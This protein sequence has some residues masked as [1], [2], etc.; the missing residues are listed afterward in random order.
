ML[1]QQGIHAAA[2]AIPI[3][4]IN[5]GM[6]Q[7]FWPWKWCASRVCAG[8]S[9][10][11]CTSSAPKPGLAGRFFGAG[12]PSG[13]PVNCSRH[14]IP[15]ARDT[16]TAR[17]RPAGKT[18]MRL[19]PL[20][21][22]S[23]Q[24]LAACC[25][26][27]VISACTTTPT[28]EYLV[29]QP[30]GSAVRRVPGGYYTYAPSRTYQTPYAPTYAPTPYTPP[31]PKSGSSFSLI[32]PAEAAPVHPPPPPRPSSPVCKLAILPRFAASSSTTSVAR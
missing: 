17:R 14:D 13:Q 32:S 11:A 25:V 5:F 22:R 20:A 24:L 27:P 26:L 9:P 29:E 19:A 4:M 2:S 8:P 1:G 15:A 28:Q 12:S 16:F 21:R 31:E 18:I 6:R 10:L 23:L 30:D 7:F 3:V